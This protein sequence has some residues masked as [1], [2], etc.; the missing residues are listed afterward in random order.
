MRGPA[1]P[2]SLEPSPMTGSEGSLSIV[3]RQPI[4]TQYGMSV[5]NQSKCEC[6]VTSGRLQA[7]M[8]FI[9]SAVLLH[10]VQTKHFNFSFLKT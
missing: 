10:Y 7:F 9:L 8:S 2:V 4:M 3:R 1:R 5:T 6:A